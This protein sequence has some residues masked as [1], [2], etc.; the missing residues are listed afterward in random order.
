MIT[1]ETLVTALGADLRP[2]TPGSLRQVVT[3]VHVSELPDPTL[4][5]RW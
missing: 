4:P 3:G 1:L 2:I 5:R